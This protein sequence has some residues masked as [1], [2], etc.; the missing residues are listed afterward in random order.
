MNSY[1]KRQWQAEQEARDAALD[2]QREKWAK[3]KERAARNAQRK[4]DR[5]ARKLSEAGKLTDWEEEFTES[6]GERL[7]KF[8]S[9][10]QDP[11]KGR[12]ADALSF[13][14]K[15]VVAA[16]KKKAKDE[17]RQKNHS[18]NDVEQT[19]SASKPQSEKKRTGFKSK[20]G[21]KN[22]NYKPRIR[23]I[24]EEFETEMVPPVIDTEPFIPEVSP[25]DSKPP[26]LR[27]V[28]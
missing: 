27:L 26:F 24:D 20:G 14:Q 4:I 5:L 2:I 1:D 15:K 18:E 10:F 23:Q 19:R 16:L 7:D 13:A 11:E 17:A 6:V 22:K 28:K 8:G 21:F 3:A 12:P 25:S 9:A